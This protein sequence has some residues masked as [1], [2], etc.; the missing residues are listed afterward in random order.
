MH[1]LTPDLSKMS[2][3][4]L[5]NK[6]RDLGVKLTQ[7]HRQGGS[8]LMSQVAMLLEDYQVELARRRQVE[9]DKIVND[10][11]DRFKGIIDIS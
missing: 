4:D 1:P 3:Q 11:P 9:F 6:I 8:A 10:N 5:N 7:A 2:D